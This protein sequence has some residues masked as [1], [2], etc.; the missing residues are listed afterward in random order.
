MVQ[1]GCALGACPVEDA[2]DQLSHIRACGG[3]GEKRNIRMRV[4]GGHSRRISRRQDKFDIGRNYSD[5][6]GE[7]V[8]IHSTR[9]H[10]VDQRQGDFGMRPH[11]LALP[12]SFVFY[13]VALTWLMF[14]LMDDY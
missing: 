3:L 12:S 10:H 9:H 2:P 8:P 4:R 13:A 7:R 11:N 14:V 6:V 5:F 1:P